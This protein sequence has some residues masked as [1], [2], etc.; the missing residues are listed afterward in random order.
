MTMMHYS[1]QT[2]E[3]LWNLRFNNTREWFQAHKAEYEA[4]MH[5]PTKDLGNALY[6]HLRDMMQPTAPSRSGTH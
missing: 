5:L 6:E 1:E 4:L 3:F 2:V